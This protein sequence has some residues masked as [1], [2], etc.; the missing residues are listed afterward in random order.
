MSQWVWPAMVDG[1]LWRGRDLRKG[2]DGGEVNSDDKT[3]AVVDS[4]EHEVGR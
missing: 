4:E 2:G 3:K 1:G